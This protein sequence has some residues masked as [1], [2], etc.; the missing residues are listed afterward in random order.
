MDLVRFDRGTFRIARPLSPTSLELLPA[1]A[2][3]NE[4]P[5]ASSASPTILHLYGLTPAS[6]QTQALERLAEWASSGPITLLAGPTGMRGPS[7]QL[8]A[9]A[10]L[11]DGRSLNE[12]LIRE[13]LAA[14]HPAPGDR[15][16]HWFAHLAATVKINPARPVKR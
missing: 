15:L 16:S 7:G 4:P 13:G 2:L 6:R 5:S 14:A 8:T 10:Y 3:F 9:A 1:S 12:L 11:S